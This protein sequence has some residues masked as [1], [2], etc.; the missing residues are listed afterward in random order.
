MHCY[1]LPNHSLA[2]HISKL[3]IPRYIYILTYL[4]RLRRRHR[5]DRRKRIGSARNIRYCFPTRA[6]QRSLSEP[7]CLQKKLKKETTPPRHSRAIP[8]I[9]TTIIIT[10]RHCHR[11]GVSSGVLKCPQVFSSYRVF[12]SSRYTEPTTLQHSVSHRICLF[13]STLIPRSARAQHES[14]IQDR[15][16]TVSRATH[17][18]TPTH[19][20]TYRHIY[21][22]IHK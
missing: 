10:A 20:H 8:V 9:I 18:L 16:S 21:T 3:H 2:G 4:T 19:A 1:C 13:Y 11:Q 6:A 5:T 22:Y 15:K 17:S 7:N 12:Q 14:A